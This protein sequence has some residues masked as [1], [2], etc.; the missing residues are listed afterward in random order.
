MK[1]IN[2]KTIEKQLPPGVDSG[3]EIKAISFGL[4][5]AVVYSLSFVYKYIDA[6]N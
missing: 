1:L 5:A 3:I 6:R 2:K 4:L